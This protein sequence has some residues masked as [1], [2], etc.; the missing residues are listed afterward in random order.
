[1]KALSQPSVP[2]SDRKLRADFT[3]VMYATYEEAKEGGYYPFRFLAMLRRRGGVG[4]AQKLL[5]D[6][7]VS[8]GFLRL[9][10]D[11]RLKISVEAIVLQA[12]FAPLFTQQQLTTAHLRLV[13]NADRRP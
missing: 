2:D 5:N 10:A 3:R 7:Y 12:R 9:E 1:M 4:A 13:S 6:R 8:D 11:G